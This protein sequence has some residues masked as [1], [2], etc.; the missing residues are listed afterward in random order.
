MR[1]HR[2][3]SKP[4]ANI[5]IT[6]L[7]DI[8]FVLLIAFMIVAPALKY[9]VELELPKVEKAPQLKQNQPITLSIT[10]GALGPDIRVNGQVSSLDDLVGD[11][12]RL[13]TDDPD[14]PVAIEADRGVDWEQMTRV[15]AALQNGSVGNIGIVTDPLD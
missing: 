4:Q 9:G 13:R 10:Q 5:N 3:V 2:V 14:R 11:I 8:V 12:E 1:R 7:L 15:V 6:S